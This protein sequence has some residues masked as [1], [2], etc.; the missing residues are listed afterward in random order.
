MAVVVRSRLR[1]G[2]VTAILW[3]KRH[4]PEF[5]NTVEDVQPN[6]KR[7]HR[8]WQREGGYDRTL[9]SARDIHE[10]IRYVHENPVRRGL[11]ER[12]ADM[13]RARRAISR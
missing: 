4:A 5:L 11:V 1:R 2:A 3:L 9:R 6:G 13:A 7:Y 8:F 10:K 12:P